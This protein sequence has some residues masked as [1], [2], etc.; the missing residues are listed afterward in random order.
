MTSDTLPINVVSDYADN[1]VAQQVSRMNGVGQ[2]Y[3]GGPRKPA[4][5]IQIDPRKAA[6]LGLQLD[7]IRASIAQGTVNAPK[8]QL[9]GAQQALTIYADDQAWTPGPGTT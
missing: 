6:A 4:I 9:I 2:V 5:R 7:Q 8:G 1:I 3:L